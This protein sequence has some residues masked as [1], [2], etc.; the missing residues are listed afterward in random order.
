MYSRD[1]EIVA[2]TLFR[3]GTESATFKTPSRIGERTKAAL[4]ELVEAG[5]LTFASKN[6]AFHYEAVSSVIGCPFKLFDLP[7]E[8]EDFPIVTKG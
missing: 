7:T 1:A 3:R 4:D 8:E 5:A 6:G 2:V